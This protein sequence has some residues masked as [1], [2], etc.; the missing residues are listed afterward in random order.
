MRFLFL[1]ALFFCVGCATTMNKVEN[2]VEKKVENRVEKKVKKKDLLK[3][4]VIIFYVDDLGWQDTEL[5]NL[6]E[7]SPWETP[8]I[9]KLAEDGLN[10][11]NGYSPAPTCAPS[12]CAILSGLHPAKTGI[13][14]V[15]GGIVPTARYTN[16]V[17]PYFPVGLMPE[18]FT[19][20]EALKENGYTT[21]HVGKWHAGGLKIQKPSK[22]GFDFVHESRG[23]HQGPKGKNNRANFFATHDTNDKYRLSDEKYA[24]F[25]KESPDGISYPHDKVTEKALEFINQSKQEPFFLYLAHWLVHAPIHTKNKELLQH[26]CDKLGVDFPTKDIPITT[27]GQTNPFY[28][29]MVTTLDWSLG[30]VVDLLKKTDDPRNPGKKL[31][32]TTYIFFSSD[33]GAVEKANRDIVT[34]NAPLDEG[35]KYA[36]E[37]GIRV[38]LVISGPNIPKG[39]TYDGLINQLDFYPTILNLTQSEIPTEYSLDLDL[40]L[41][42]I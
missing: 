35:K 29:S 7:P 13:T 41:I 3:P 40:S 20:A 42:H 16:Y 31:Y 23:A 21:G 9:S 39:K 14:H 33:N 25:T 5:N 6:D 17:A 38:P 11:S 34:D 28:G 4:N 22:Q 19:I 32:E 18:N 8:N 27:K 15:A 30:R 12:R 24:P 1:V 10:F 26:Y 37:G 2:S 36:Q